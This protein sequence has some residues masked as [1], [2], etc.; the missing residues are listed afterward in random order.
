MRALPLLLAWGLLSAPCWSAERWR[1]QFFH[2]EDATT[3]TLRDLKFPTPQRGIAVGEIAEGRR[4]KP[5]ALLTNDGGEHWNTVEIP[6][7]ARS[8]FFRSESLGWMV[9]ASGVW[10]TEE[11]GRNWKRL[12]RLEGLVRVH[13]V[14]D[15]HGWAV[16]T[17]KAVYETRDGGLHWTPV[18]AA[19][20]PTATR[21]FT[22][23]YSID[24]LNEQVGLIAG[25]SRPPRRERQRLPDWMEPEKSRNRKEWPSLSIL[26]ETRDGGQ[27]WRFSGSSMFG[28]ISQVRLAQDGRGLALIRFMEAF[29]WPAEVYLLDWR[30]GRSTRVFRHPERDVTDVA[31]VSGGTAYLA[32]IEPA[33]RIPQSPIPGKLKILKSID[34]TNWQETEVDYRAVGRHVVLATAGEGHLW[35]AT[36]TGM[37]LK[38]ASE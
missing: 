7:A 38:L 30:S 12:A 26:L 32:A 18:P 37:I 13:F 33:S 8:L 9:T 23:Y 6:E 31:L 22:A 21:E 36:D 11:A 35:A 14:S 19:A 25:S 15:Q 24:F 10:R 1:L 27:T 5:V 16:G 3:L 20:E 28:V 29:D 2:D 34:W 4:V 17:L